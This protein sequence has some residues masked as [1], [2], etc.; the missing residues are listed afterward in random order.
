MAPKASEKAPRDDAA[1]EVPAVEG[2]SKKGSKKKAATGKAGK[3]AATQ[4]LMGGEKKKKEQYRVDKNG[5]KHRKKKPSECGLR[6]H[7]LPVPQ[8]QLGLFPPIMNFESFQRTRSISTRC[9]FAMRQ[10]PGLRD[11]GASASIGLVHRHITFRSVYVRRCSSRS[12]PTPASPR[13]P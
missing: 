11:I 1:H 2:G 7:C 5:A 3:A 13:R 12:T 9:A 4:P 6:S 8:S 10:G